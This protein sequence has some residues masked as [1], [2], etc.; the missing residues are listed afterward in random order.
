MCEVIASGVEDGD[1]SVAIN[2]RLE[3]WLRDGLL[4]R[5]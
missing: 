3:T 2:Q 1:P 5:E 4:I